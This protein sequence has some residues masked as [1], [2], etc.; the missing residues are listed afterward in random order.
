M[1]CGTGLNFNEWFFPGGWGR[2][3]DIGF[4]VGGAGE[5]TLVSGWVGQGR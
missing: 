3:D 4:R 1:S 2:G 5:M